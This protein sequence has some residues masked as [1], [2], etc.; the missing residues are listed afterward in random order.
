MN[1]KGI[2]ML[3][4]IITIIV[5][6]ILATITVYYSSKTVED[7]TKKNIMEEMKNVENV[8]SAAKAKGL[9]GDFTPNEEY[10]IT[11]EQLDKMF[12]GVLTQEQIQNI[13]NINN[14][15][16]ADPLEKYYLLDQAGFDSEFRNN[17]I[18]TV[19]GL[20]RQYLVSYDSRVILIN[21]NGSL[22]S[23]GKIDST[24]PTKSEIKV[25]FSPN[26][27]K[28]WKKEHSAQ[29]SVTGDNVNIISTQYTWT[30]SEN[31]ASAILADRYN[32]AGVTNIDLRDKTGNDWYIWVWVKY[33]EEDGREKQYV[34]RSNAFYIDNTSPTGELE[35]NE[36]KK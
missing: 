35:V 23:S 3:T 30:N 22:V 6:I 5:I 33:T 36:I 26:G 29:I 16:D 13:K 32:F 9:A 8:I 18:I 31:E 15:D 21:D 25:V 1:N 12:S 11:D 28:S 19:N 27:S 14:D 2:S 24:T 20:K 4:L 17:D 7:A 34:Q 10:I